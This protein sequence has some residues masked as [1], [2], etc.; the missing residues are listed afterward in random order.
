[1]GPYRFLLDLGSP[2][3]Q[4]SGYL[5]QVYFAMLASRLRFLLNF[6]T[7][8]GCAGL[9][10]QGFDMRAITENNCRRSWISHDL[11][12]PFFMILGSLGTNLHY[13]GGHDFSG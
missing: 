2:F 9:E 1:M 11:L 6:G 12:V 4:L 3:R 5:K 13:F 10:N 8:S 7:E